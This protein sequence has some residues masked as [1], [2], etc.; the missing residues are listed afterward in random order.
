MFEVDQ[1]ILARDQ[2]SCDL[3]IQPLSPTQPYV[4][5]PINAEERNLSVFEPIVR[6]LHDF[7]LGGEAGNKPAPPATNV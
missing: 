4:A 7:V 5:T 3:V 2:N 6:G 1:S